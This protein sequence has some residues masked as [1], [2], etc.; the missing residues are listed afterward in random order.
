MHDLDD[1]VKTVVGKVLDE[2]A[3]PGSP[4]RAPLSRMTLQAAKVLAA[5]V[6]EQAAVMGVNAVVA[7]SDA[8]GNLMLC[9]C[10]DDAFLASRDIAINKAYTVTALKM[11]TKALASLAAPGGSLYGIQFTNGGRIVIFGGGEPLESGGKIVG[12]VGVSGG[13]AEED[14]KLGEIAKRYFETHIA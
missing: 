14:T 3:V 4:K 1:I 11:P 2:G 7:V 13:T 9:E 5:Y 10:M 12:G 6:E 8:S